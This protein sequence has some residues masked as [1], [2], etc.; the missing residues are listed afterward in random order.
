MS[1]RH[2]VGFALFNVGGMYNMK[3]KRLKYIVATCML[4]FI[5]ILIGM[6]V[7]DNFIRP[8]IGDVLVVCVI[9]TFIRVFIPEKVRLLPLWI[10]IF[11]LSVELL[12][13]INIV[14]ILG[15]KKGSLLAIIIG[16][17]FDLKDVICYGVGCLFI[18]IGVILF[19]HRGEAN[20]K[21][22]NDKEINGEESNSR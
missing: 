4:L 16:S 14:D 6:F 19:R 5:E 21:E 2:N 20:S 9:Y 15:I 11:A 3:S 7:H 18:A 8:Y 12:Q 1:I 13:L 10:F 17:T 22:C